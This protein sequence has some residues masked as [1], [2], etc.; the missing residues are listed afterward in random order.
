V[1]PLAVVPDLYELDDGRARRR[2]KKAIT[3]LFSQFP[4]VSV[5]LPFLS[6]F[7]SLVLV[8]RAR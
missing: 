5:L 7:Q 3:F 6:V 8:F 2:S 4:F 1:S